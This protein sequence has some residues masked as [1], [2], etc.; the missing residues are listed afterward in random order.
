MTGRRP[1]LVTGVGGAA[2]RSLVDQ[3]L[4]RG[5]GVVGVD[6]TPVWHAGAHCARV[7]AA[8]DPGFVP[9][10]LDIAT[11]TG[12]RLVIPTVA[13]EIGVPGLDILG[14]D[15]PGG[16][17]PVVVGPRRAV[18]VAADR[19]LTCRR[20][21]DAGVPVPRHALP[22][23]LTT[24][25]GV[26]DELGLP[27]LSRPRRGGG[28]AVHSDPAVVP[29]LADTMILQEYVPGE[30]YSVNLYL[31]RDPYRDLVVVLQRPRAGGRVG[32]AR[33]AAFAVRRVSAPDVADVAY[34]AARAI[35]LTGPAD[36]AVRRR[37]DGTPV[38]LNIDARFGTHS[39]H[40]HEVLDAVLTE[41]LPAH[42]RPAHARP[43]AAR[44]VRA[45]PR[46]WRR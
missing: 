24:P 44:P 21:D 13:D 38:V 23:R 34:R 14:L 16:G 12:A 9:A 1:I 8:T 32:R 22:S 3:L 15:Q 46:S 6:R 28:K 10:L 7:P 42:A 43:A 27:F 19:W 37:A 35:G 2:G 29:S 18:A 40:A 39:A 26:A 31:G 11:G 41:H 17:P 25:D 30:E 45:L 4:E 20:L 36:I 5:L 33:S